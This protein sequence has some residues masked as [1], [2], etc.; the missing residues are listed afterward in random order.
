M[1]ALVQTGQLDP[2][3][4]LEDDGTWNTT[5]LCALIQ[6]HVGASAVDTLLKR[7]A[8]VNK[9]CYKLVDGKVARLFDLGRTLPLDVVIARAALRGSL[10]NPYNQV[11]QYRPEHVPT[12]I[13]YAEKLVARGGRS[14]TGSMT[15]VEV[16]QK[17]QTQIDNSNAYLP[18]RIKA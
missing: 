7:G 3:E 8:D 10:N 15:M 11:N 6:T 13:G 18:E 2:N 9:P 14:E 17:I 4:Y 16:R 5:P 12:Y 1:I